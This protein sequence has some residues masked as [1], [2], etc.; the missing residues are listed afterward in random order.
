MRPTLASHAVSYL[1]VR[2]IGSASRW[3]L[4]SALVR[5]GLWRISGRSG[6]L[7]PGQFLKRPIRVLVSG[8]VFELRP[9]CDDLEYV[10]PRTKRPM[11]DWFRP[12]PGD[13]VVD[14]GPHIGFNTIQAARRGA[15]VV[16]FE[17]NPHTF[18]ALR[19]NVDLNRLQGVHLV[20]AAA[21]SSEA[22]GELRV[23]LLASG[24]GSLRSDWVPEDKVPSNSPI[25]RIDVRIVRLDDS[26]A[27]FDWPRTDW[28]IVDVEGMEAEVL[29]GAPL[30]LARTQR[31]IIEVDVRS[32]RP[33][34]VRVAAL[35]DEAGLTVVGR[36]PQFVRTEYWL[37]QRGRS[38][39]PA[40]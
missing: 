18:Q 35:L 15:Q 3:S 37:A 14:V 12:S 23:P 9:A 16:A 22:A 6:Y 33:S 26:L 39:R 17:P 4:Y 31:A 34:A 1:R 27:A 25:R 28:L 5:A 19:T 7:S 38:T 21:G 10:L 29:A 13:F 24:F 36:F 8:S 20:G 2:P 32:D 30:T 11:V 40:A